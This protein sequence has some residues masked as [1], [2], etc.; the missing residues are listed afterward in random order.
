V[1]AALLNS[2]ENERTGIV[3]LDFPAGGVSLGQSLVFYDDDI[4]LGGGV[5]IGT[6]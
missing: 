4:L 2:E 3:L 5:I 1:R 6:E